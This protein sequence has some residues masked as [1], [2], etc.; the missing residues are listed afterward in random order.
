M[1]LEKKL[2]REEEIEKVSGGAPAQGT[3]VDS[4]IEKITCPF[5]SHPKV[6]KGIRTYYDPTSGRVNEYLPY[7]CI[8]CGKA[9]KGTYVTG[10]TNFR[11]EW[12]G[13]TEV[14]NE[15]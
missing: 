8:E 4:K 2:L 6:Y 13:V 12:R 14:A 15:Y 11:T 7:H 9:W 10:N 1:E 3:V 5:C